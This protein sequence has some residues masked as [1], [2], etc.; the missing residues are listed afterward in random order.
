MAYFY[1]LLGLISLG[2]LG[3]LHKVAD[4]Q[5]C[6]PAAVNMFL[7][8]WAG[9]V[10]VGILL[11]KV[12]PER[13]FSVPWRIIAVAAV[14]GGFSSVAILTLQQALRHGKIS[15]SWLVINLSTA[16]PTVLSIVIYREEVGLRRSFSFLLVVA[17]LLL[18]WWDRKKGETVNPGKNKSA[19]DFL[20]DEQGG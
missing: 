4:H 13:S 7:F 20:P 8:L 10:S 3:V 12:G 6:R 15:T 17:S 14:C 19:P 11:A 18:L 5:A 2:G 9:L 1:L 16:I